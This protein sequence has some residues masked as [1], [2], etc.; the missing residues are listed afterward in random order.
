MGKLDRRIDPTTKDYVPDGK[1][2]FQLTDTAEVAGYLQIAIHRDEYAYDPELGSNA[3]KLP[4]TNLSAAGIQ[5][6][7]EDLRAAL[8][9]LVEAG[10]ARDVEVDVGV[11]D[12]K[13]HRLCGSTSIVDTKGTRRTVAEVDAL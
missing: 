13:P 9:L 1:G 5:F 2:G 10:I 11:T 7:T 8:M 12:T 6:A 4:R 3:H